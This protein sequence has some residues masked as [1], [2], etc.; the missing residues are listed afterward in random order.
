MLSSHFTATS[1]LSRKNARQTVLKSS[2]RY[3]V[4]NFEGLDY[5]CLFTNNL[6]INLA[7]RCKHGCIIIAEKNKCLKSGNSMLECPQHNDFHLLYAFFIPLLF[8]FDFLWSWI[9]TKL[10]LMTDSQYHN[11]EPIT[12]VTTQSY[13][14]F[15]HP[16]KNV[17]SKENNKE[18]E[19]ILSK[20]T[21]LV[22]ISKIPPILLVNRDILI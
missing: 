11:L 3:Y 2:S 15:F 20:N 22:V 21:L 13:I 14:S 16:F 12:C 6:L 18:K 19:W 9:V 7:S 1:L 8:N 5:S 10:L 4:V 17:H